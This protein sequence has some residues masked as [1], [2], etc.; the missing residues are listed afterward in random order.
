VRSDRDREGIAAAAGR[1]GVRVFDLE[2]GAHQIL[3]EIDFGA[4]E[5]VERHIVDDD[6]D[7][8]ALED[9][10][11]RVS[12]IVKAQPVLKPGAAAADTA[13]RRNASPAASCCLRAVNR[14]AALSV[15]TTPR[16]LATSDPR[17]RTWFPTL[18]CALHLARATATVYLGILASGESRRMRIAAVGAPC[19]V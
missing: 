6:R 16:S 10:I 9:E 12:L 1:G 8:V 15:M 19:R 3:D 14:R 11:V 2:R 7:T 5:Q 17:L 18:C 4:V 13:M